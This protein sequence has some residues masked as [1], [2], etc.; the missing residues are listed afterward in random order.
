MIDVVRDGLGRLGID[1][2]RGVP[3]VGSVTSNEN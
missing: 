1:M 2:G 3:P